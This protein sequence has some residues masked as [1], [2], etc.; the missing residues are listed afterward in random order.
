VF[1]SDF[2]TARLHVSETMNMQDNN[3]RNVSNQRTCW[4]LRHSFCQRLKE[5][6]MKKIWQKHKH[7]IP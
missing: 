2:Y 1:S 3:A 7:L 4:R 6:K 5:Y